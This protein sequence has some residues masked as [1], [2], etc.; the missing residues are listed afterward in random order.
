MVMKK[1]RV[2]ALEILRNQGGVR[3]AASTV[4]AE[5]GVTIGASCITLCKEGLELCKCAQPRLCKARGGRAT[6]F[7]MHRT[8]DALQVM[9]WLACEL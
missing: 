2:P 5:R 6:R 1:G 8:P 7:N 3:C 4:W 9:F